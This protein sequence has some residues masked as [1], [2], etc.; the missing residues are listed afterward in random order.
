MERKKITRKTSAEVKPEI[1]KVNTCVYESVIVTINANS[2][3][4][5]TNNKKKTRGPYNLY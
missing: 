1:K 4:E 5:R 2:E 3:N